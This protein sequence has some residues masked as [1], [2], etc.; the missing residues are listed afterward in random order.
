MRTFYTI[1]DALAFLKSEIER[2]ERKMKKEKNRHYRHEIESLIEWNLERGLEMI[3]L[4]S[5]DEAN[6]EVIDY[7]VG[8]K[9]KRP[10]LLKLEELMEEGIEEDK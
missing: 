3:K 7:F 10:D 8:R 5:P 1:I 2:L 4:A 6:Q 9:K